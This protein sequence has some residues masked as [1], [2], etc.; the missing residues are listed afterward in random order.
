MAVLSQ[1]SPAWGRQGILAGAG[2]LVLLGVLLWKP[3]FLF[4]ADAA[5]PRAETP[6]RMDASPMV[7]RVGDVE[8]LVVFGLQRIAVGEPAL[9]EINVPH[10]GVVR[11]RGK[12]E[13]STRLIMWTD[14]GE[15]TS[16]VVDVIVR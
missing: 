8:E 9:V 3:S 6:G 1:P 10:P 16:R 11:L 15:M 14:D 2:S 5:T 12:V 4:Q 13:G 7:L